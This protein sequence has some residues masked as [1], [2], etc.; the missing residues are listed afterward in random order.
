MPSL[1][2]VEYRMRDAGCKM[3]DARYMM[4]DAGYRMQDR[5]GLD[6]GY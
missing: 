2:P 5:K 4:Q 1:G 6:S 3:Q